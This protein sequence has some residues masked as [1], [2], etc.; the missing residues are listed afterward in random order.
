VDDYKALVTMNAWR[1]TA[2]SWAKWQEPPV[3][4][5]RVPPGWED[6]EPDGAWHA[7]TERLVPRV[8]IARGVFLPILRGEAD[9]Y[10]E[11]AYQ[12]LRDYWEGQIRYKREGSPKG[13]DVPVDLECPFCHHGVGTPAPRNPRYRQ[14][15]YGP[16]ICT[17][18]GVAFATR[19][20]RQG[21]AMFLDQSRTLTLVPRDNR[22][23]PLQRL[24]LKW[25][26]GDAYRI[27]ATLFQARGVQLLNAYL[28]HGNAV[29]AGKVVGMNRHT[30]K[31]WF[32]QI[33]AADL[34]QPP[35]LDTFLE[36]PPIHM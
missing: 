6:L 24:I 32:D 21:P 15:S 13:I 30:V 36:T 22:P 10:P 1:V 33:R 34:L 8:R 18:C 20:D 12:A 27:A 23:D 14:V 2:K 3:E 26:I 17:K 4:P 28:D 7:L 11:K 29:G 35:S 19:P 31:A 16:H 25:R 9:K 5:S